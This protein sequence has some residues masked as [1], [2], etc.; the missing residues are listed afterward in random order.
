MLAFMKMFLFGEIVLGSAFMTFTFTR[1]AIEEYSRC[2]R[3]R[4]PVMTM[5]FMFCTTLAVQALGMLLYS[6]AWLFAAFG[7]GLAWMLTQD[8]FGLEV[9]ALGL[10]LIVLGKAALI[11]IGTQD[12]YR[13]NWWMFV[14][15]STGWLAYVVLFWSP[16][17]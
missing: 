17:V 6:P 3:T 4:S 7:S 12:R 2:K 14:V 8:P 13:S 15:L 9:R 5:P 10:L 1:L 16:P 11:Y